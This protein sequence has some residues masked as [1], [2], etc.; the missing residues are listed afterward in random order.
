MTDEFIGSDVGAFNEYTFFL[1][2]HF[3]L[4]HDFGNKF[5]GIGR[6]LPQV[7]PEAGLTISDTRFTPDGS[8]SSR[9]VVVYPSASAEGG[10][11]S[12]KLLIRNAQG[13]T[14]R[15][16]EGNG[17]PPHAQQWDGLSPEGQPLP[18]GPYRISLDVVDLYGNEA[19]SPA[20]IVEIQS[21]SPRPAV[22]EVST[23]TT[24]A[25]PAPVAKPYSVTATP[26]GLRV[27]LS[28]LILF[29]VDKS[30]LKDSAKEGLD[31]VIQMLQAYPTNS[32]RI[33]GHTDAI[34]SDMHNQKLS[35]HRAQ[36]VADYLMQKGRITKD[37]IHVVGYGKHRPLASNASESG[38]Q[39]NRRVEI[40]ILK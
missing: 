12:W 16:W 39:Q 1:T 37:R 40:D 28:S 3:A 9:V 2:Y 24:P 11:L 13:Q 23:P 10:I 21:L 17:N 22:P 7:F 31:Q 6:P 36:A 35:E 20:V 19:T 5:Q 33:S 8:G 27:T 4:Q 29:D 18:I 14:V 38:R 30:D 34:G 26:E 25:P 15:K 32:L